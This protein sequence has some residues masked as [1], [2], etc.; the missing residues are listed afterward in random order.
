LRFNN[1]ASCSNGTE[2]AYK[3]A[4]KSLRYNAENRGKNRLVV[5]RASGKSHRNAVFTMRIGLA[6]EDASFITSNASDVTS[7]ASD[8]TS[9]ASDVTSNASDV[10][11]NA[12]DV[13]CGASD[14]SLAGSDATR[15]A[16]DATREASDATREASDVALE[17]AERSSHG[18]TL[19]TTAW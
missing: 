9:N 3:T 10:T 6:S 17:V 1:A 2:R 19:S 15:E 14:V 12:S 16:S 7:N 11:S 5:V 18:S 13:T 4:R 8:V